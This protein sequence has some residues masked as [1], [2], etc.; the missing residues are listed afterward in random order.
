MP[1]YQILTVL[2][3]AQRAALVDMELDGKSRVQYFL[4]IANSMYVGADN[5]V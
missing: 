1:I 4:T 5:E 3:W 2:P